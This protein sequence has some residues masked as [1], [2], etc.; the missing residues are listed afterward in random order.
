MELL[1]MVDALTYRADRAEQKARN[2]AVV[3]AEIREQRNALEDERDRAEQERDAMAAAADRMAEAIE[4]GLGYVPM[5]DAADA[6]RALRTGQG[7][8]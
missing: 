8:G 1:E 4:S 2:M 5:K 7:E 3:V 6:Y